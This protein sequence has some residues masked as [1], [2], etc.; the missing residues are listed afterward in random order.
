V[1]V[2]DDR[3]DRRGITDATTPRAPYREYYNQMMRDVPRGR[4][5]VF[6]QHAWKQPDEEIHVWKYVLDNGVI[7]AQ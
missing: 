2:A 4:Q 6:K 5:G 3:Q 7:Y 1:F